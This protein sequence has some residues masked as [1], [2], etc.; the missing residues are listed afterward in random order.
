MAPVATIM[1]GICGMV[2]ALAGWL[3]FG[4]GLWG[5]VQLYLIV[6]TVVA[7]ALIALSLI[8]VPH[9]EPTAGSRKERRLQQA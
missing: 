8:R 2:S 4:A 5:A 7:I 1:G 3:F 6:G 9:D